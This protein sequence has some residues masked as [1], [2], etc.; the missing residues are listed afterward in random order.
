MPDQSASTIP[1]AGSAK[2]KRNEQGASFAE[3]LAW[4]VTPFLLLVLILLLDH[5]ADESRAYQ[6]PSLTLLLG[7]IFTTCTS[8][9]VAFLAGRSFLQQ[10]SISLLALGCG[11]LTLGIGGVA[12]PLVSSSDINGQIAI[13]NIS[14]LIS[15]AFHLIG[16][17]GAV[18]SKKLSADTRTFLG[19]AYLFAAVLMAATIIMVLEGLVPPFFIQSHGGTPLR[20][21]VLISAIGMFGVSA[22]LLQKTKPN[23]VGRWYALSLWLLAVGL[24]GVL[25][26]SSQGSLVGWAGPYGS[27]HRWRLYAHCLHHFGTSNFRM[28][29]DLRGIAAPVRSAIPDTL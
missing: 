22:A 11:A 6:L 25:Q 4:N 29:I 24:F 14:V 15:A 7:F 8:F 5:L 13:H 21:V 17:S 1:D 16:A 28:E 18:K 23:N 2:A 20:F 3:V 27:V 12:S 26:Q 10:D 19:V 9:L